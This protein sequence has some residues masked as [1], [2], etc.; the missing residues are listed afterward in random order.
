MS[1]HALL[2]ALNASDPQVSEAARQALLAQ[3]ESTLDELI[4]ALPQL[5]PRSL[6]K[7]ISVLGASAHP[8]CDAALLEL[9]SHDHS[10]VRLTAVQALGNFHS[11]KACLAL[12]EQLASPDV[13]IQISAAASPGKLGNPLALEALIAQLLRTPE[14]TVR[15]STIRA[16]GQLGDVRAEEV[17]LRFADDPNHHVRSD[18]QQALERLG[19]GPP[20]EQPTD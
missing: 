9:L 13:M 16:L 11:D 18:V 1:L 3:G 7:V 20:P 2:D 15:Y 17:I 10:L 5:A 14:Q 12:M 8:R 19:A 6:M 4:E